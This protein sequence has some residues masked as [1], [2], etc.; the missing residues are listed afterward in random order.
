MVAAGHGAI[1]TR[2]TVPRSQLQSYTELLRGMPG[3]LS[4]CARI[5]QRLLRVMTRCRRHRSTEPRTA[6]KTLSIPASQ[7][8]Q[9]I[10]L[11]VE[12]HSMSPSDHPLPYRWRLGSDLSNILR[13]H[14]RPQSTVYIRCDLLAGFYIQAGSSPSLSRARRWSGRGSTFDCLLVSQQ[15]V[16]LVEKP[17]C[18]VCKR[19][20][21]KGKD[22]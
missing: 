5:W 17:R 22:V 15:C 8:T 4:R 3:G 14:F 10:E 6:N 1:A 13:T 21:V 20:E 19:F 2:K 7:A 18:A 16:A 12:H 9:S 11:T